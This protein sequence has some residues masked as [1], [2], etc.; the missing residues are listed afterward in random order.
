MLDPIRTGAPSITARVT[1]KTPAQEMSGL[2]DR[3]HKHTQDQYIKAG[4]VRLVKAR[5]AQIGQS[6]MWSDWSI[7]D[8]VDLKSDLKFSFYKYS[9]FSG[10]FS[11]DHGATHI[12]D[13]TFAHT[14]STPLLTASL[15]PQIR[16]PSIFPTRHYSVPGQLHRTQNEGILDPDTSH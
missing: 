7:Q 2:L 9:Q 13:N 4:C 14:S 10:L 16:E 6:Q 1:T 15:R 12:E 5:C 3:Q 11:D 8:V